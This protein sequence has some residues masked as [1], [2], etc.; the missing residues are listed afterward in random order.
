MALRWITG[1]EE[2]AQNLYVDYAKNFDD[3][4]TKNN[5][6][7]PN[8]LD[9]TDRGVTYFYDIFNPEDIRTYTLVSEQDDEVIPIYTR[10]Y[11]IYKNGLLLF[12]GLRS[13]KEALKHGPVDELK[14]SLQHGRLGDKLESKEG[15]SK[16]LE[17][18][19]QI[20]REI[21]IKGDK[22]DWDGV[23]PNLRGMPWPRG[24]MDYD[25]EVWE[26]EEFLRTNY[27]AY[28]KQFD[29]KTDKETFRPTKEKT[30]AIKRLG[31]LES[32]VTGGKPLTQ[33]IYTEGFEPTFGAD[34]IM[35]HA[36]YKNV[37]NALKD[38]GFEELEWPENQDD[39]V[40]L[41]NEYRKSPLMQE[42]IGLISKKKPKG[43]LLIKDMTTNKSWQFIIKGEKGMDWR[44]ILKNIGLIEELDKVF[45]KPF[46]ADMYAIVTRLL[47][48]IQRSYPN[49]FRTNENMNDLKGVLS[50]MIDEADMFYSN[51]RQLEALRMKEVLQNALDKVE[52]TDR[53][54]EE[55][56]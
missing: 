22:P 6:F 36:V 2:T 8:H 3:K 54:V 5:I 30:E 24:F 39:E 23:N 7:P 17:R 48:S 52:Y 13:M 4:Y 42:V 55:L 14:T 45:S 21:N 38:I 15:L 35:A 18:V 29:A 9:G 49:V 34:F 31:Q 27:P 33:V 10:T 44:E 51:T 11:G 26:I 56:T 1:D 41:E 40:I 46:D 16:Y 47:I 53:R 28:Y 25:A 43:V 50:Q 37:Q 12:M 32:K 20:D 19:K